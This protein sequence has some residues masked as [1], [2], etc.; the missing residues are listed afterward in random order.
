MAGDLAW[1][2]GCQAR[3]QA[4][5]CTLRRPWDYA[6]SAASQRGGSA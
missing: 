2:F 6:A 4:E 3:L 5:I 1:I